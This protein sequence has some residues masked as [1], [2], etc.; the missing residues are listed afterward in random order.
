[1]EYSV[2]I[3]EFSG[4]LDLLLHLIEKAKVD[5]KNVFISEITEQYLEYVSKMSEQ[6]MELSSDFIS[7]AATL[8]LIKSRSLLPK[9]EEDQEQFDEEYEKQ[10]IID[11]L[12]EYRTIKNSTGELRIYEKVAANYFT[13]LP[14]E[15]IIKQAL[16]LDDVDKETLYKAFV[17]VMQR[18]KIKPEDVYYNYVMQDRFNVT[19][20]IEYITGRLK[21]KKKIS[22]DEL[23][24]DTKTK[25]EVVVTFCALL[26]LLNKQILSLTQ[27]GPFNSIIIVSKDN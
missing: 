15:I 17:E 6:D 12:E 5:I 13:K 16:K 27:N 9:H 24:E 10:L 21:D 25:I 23:F 11:R 22:F 26:E 18:K 4:P 20:R 19:E 1:M 3:S 7:I 14:E 2:E 8:L